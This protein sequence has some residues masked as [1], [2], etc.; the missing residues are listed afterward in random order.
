MIKIL[1]ISQKFGTTGSEKYL[2]DLISHLDKTKYDISLLSLKNGNLQNIIKGIKEYSL[3]NFFHEQRRAIYSL[4]NKI[5]NNNNLEAKYFKGLVDKIDPDLIYINTLAIPLYIEMVYN[6]KRKFVI[7]S[8]ELEQALFH[9]SYQNSILVD[10]PELIITC[11]NSN[12]KVLEILGRNDKIKVLNPAIDLNQVNPSISNNIIR[13]QLG[14]AEDDFV[15]VMSGGTDINKDPIIFV[16]IAQIIVSRHPNAKFLWIGGN[17]DEGTGLY[18]KMLSKHLVLQKNVFW[19]NHINSDSYYN[20]LNIAD[21]LLL[22]S[23][24]DSFPLVMIENAAL[25]KPIVSFNSGGVSEF[26]NSP[27]IGYV[28]NERSIEKMTDVMINIMLDPSQFNKQTIEM[29]ALE[30]DIKKHI[31]KWEE[32]ISTIL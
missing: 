23:R 21:C 1:F 24:R 9:N 28:I 13:K 14:I 6:T 11:S 4:I 25:G 15:W 16:E 32:I 19:I 29:R 7:H 20:F 12:L 27:K 31:I 5:F 3:E 2:F 17:Q 22:T 8:H 18:S 10:Y 30:F 26:V